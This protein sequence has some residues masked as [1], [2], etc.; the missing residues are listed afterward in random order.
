MDRSLVAW[1]FADNVNCA[2]VERNEAGLVLH[3]LRGGHRKLM[4]RLR[5]SLNRALMV[6]KK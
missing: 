1:M 5:W 6:G 2:V 4:G 3:V